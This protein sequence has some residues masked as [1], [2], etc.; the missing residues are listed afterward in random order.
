MDLEPIQYKLEEYE[1][2]EHRF[3]TGTLEIEID[4]VDD[5]PYIWAFELDV[6]DEKTK[7]AVTHYFD[8]GKANNLIGAT[9]IRND[10]H[11]DQRLMREIFDD[12]AAAAMWS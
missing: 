1:L 7:R 9:D 2:P 11:R 4:P 5:S 3:L 10:L 8:A 12:C 6:K